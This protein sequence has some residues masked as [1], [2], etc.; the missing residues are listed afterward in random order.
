MIVIALVVV[1]GFVGSALLGF[2]D[3]CPELWESVAEHV[4]EDQSCGSYRIQS[5]PNTTRRPGDTLACGGRR[6]VYEMIMRG[7]HR[8]HDTA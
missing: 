6:V 8:L 5:R 1:G 2:V 3:W 7:H 4:P